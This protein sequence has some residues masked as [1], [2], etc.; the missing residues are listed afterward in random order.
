M[1]QS[2]GRVKLIDTCIGVSSMC[3]QEINSQLKTYA[4]AMYL[5]RYVITYV[6]QSLVFTTQKATSAKKVT[7]FVLSQVQLVITFGPLQKKVFNIGFLIPELDPQGEITYFLR[8]V[9]TYDHTL[10]TSSWTRSTLF[11]YEVIVH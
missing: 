7:H 6:I 5:R 9:Y 8:K 1:T 10:F 2:N 4:S 11:H 3:L